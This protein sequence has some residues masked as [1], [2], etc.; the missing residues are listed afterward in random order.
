MKKMTFPILSTIAICFTLPLSAMAEDISCTASLTRDTSNPYQAKRYVLASTISSRYY[1]CTTVLQQLGFDLNFLRKASDA[2]LA[3]E[4][5]VSAIPVTPTIGIHALSLTQQTSQGESQ[6]QM[7]E[8]TKAGELVELTEQTAELNPDAVVDATQTGNDS[9]I[10]QCRYDFIASLGES[11]TG[12]NPI[13][14]T[15]VEAQVFQETIAFNGD[16]AGEG[17]STTP[18]DIAVER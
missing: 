17:L 12:P 11:G 6:A 3:K 15:G 18:S 10:I 5:T 13:D 8:T 2:C 16:M 4:S 7:S 9:T 1:K 14:T